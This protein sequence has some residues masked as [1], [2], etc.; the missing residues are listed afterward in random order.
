MF[1]YKITLGGIMK[2]NFRCVLQVAIISVAFLS[3]KAVAEVKLPE[4]FNDNMVLQREIKVPIWGWA[5]PG[6]KVAVEIAGQKV[7]TVAD[8]D[9]KWKLKLEPLKAGTN[10]EMVVTGKNTIKFKNVAV[11]EVW[12]CSGQSNMEWPLSRADNGREEIKNADYPEIRLCNIPTVIKG[13]PSDK[14]KCK[15]DI[16]KGWNAGRFSAVGYFFGRGLYKE[17][18]IPI[19]LI[20]TNLSGSRIEPWT[21]PVGFASKPELKDISEQIKKAD[22]NYLENLKQTISTISE[23]QKWLEN[24]EKEAKKGKRLPELPEWPVHQLSTNKQF[25]T[26]LYN[27]MIHPIVPYAI[28]G[29]IWYQGESNMNDGEKYITKMEALVGGWRKIWSEGDFPFYYVQISPYSR[30]S[31]HPVFWEAQNKAWKIISN[32]GMVVIT[33]LGKNLHPTNKQDVGKRLAIMALAKTY[34]KD[35][36]VY[37]GPQYKGMKVEGKQ[38]C[39]EFDNAPNG[40]ASRN[41]KP[42]IWFEIAGKDGKFLPATAKIDGSKVLLS[43]EKITKPTQARFAWSGDAEPNFM[44]KEGFSCSAFRTQ[45]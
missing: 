7:E 17:L 20:G 9:G 45:K 4:I 2:I 24:A 19:G 22:E 23:K 34:K 25:P 10:L 41:G 35:I 36:P 43:N 18:K 30:N 1:C 15:W 42:L 11:G 37:Q 16:C 21:P 6:E 28:R 26:A 14:I 5:E 12:I 3:I 29:A 32:S 13:T 27:C 40:L 33:D 39:L 31:G 8:K 44:N 38:I